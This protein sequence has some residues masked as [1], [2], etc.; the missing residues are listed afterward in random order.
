MGEREMSKAK[1]TILGILIGILSAILWPVYKD[2]RELKKARDLAPVL[3][4]DEKAKVII[5]DR[6]VTTVTKDK[7]TVKRGVRNPVITVKKDGTVKVI[8]PQLGFIF[9][10]GMCGFYS[11][12]FYGGIDA[13]WFYWRQLGVYSGAGLSTESRH[14]RLNINLIGVGY[15]FTNKYFSNTSVFMAYNLNQKWSIGLRVRF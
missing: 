1:L 7:T 9:E 4:E 8:A 6:K 14:I 15:N 2:Y 5:K 11:D 10:P 13:Q 12:R 3:T